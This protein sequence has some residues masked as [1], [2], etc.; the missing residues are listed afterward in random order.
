MS[1]LYAAI[2]KL[3]YHARSAR[4]QVEKYS[5]DINIHAAEVALNQ[6]SI[7]DVDNCLRLIDIYNAELDSYNAA[8]DILKMSVVNKEVHKWDELSINDLVLFIINLKA[9]T[10]KNPDLAY[11]NDPLLAS[12]QIALERRQ[13]K[14]GNKL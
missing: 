13:T 2:D 10:A 7:I 12:Y 1:K 9:S 8:L 3:E 4:K 6:W 14:R 5:N 11:F